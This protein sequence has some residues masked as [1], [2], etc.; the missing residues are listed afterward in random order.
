MQGV[1]RRGVSTALLFAAILPF[2]ASS[3]AAADGKNAVR[4]TNARC[5]IMLQQRVKVMPGKY[6]DI[7]CMA[8]TRIGYMEFRLGN[9][10]ET[11]GGKFVHN[12]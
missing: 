1:S 2:V 8:R 5:G 4:F 3:A 11:K 6:Y 10:W 12:V 9:H 7:S